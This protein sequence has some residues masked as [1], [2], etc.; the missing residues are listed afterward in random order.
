MNIEQ[1]DDRIAEILA[2]DH[3]LDEVNIKLRLLQ[4]TI[5]KEKSKLLQQ[6]KIVDSEYQDVVDVN[7]KNKQLK[8]LGGLDDRVISME[9]DEYRLAF[10]NLKKLKNELVALEYQE[11]VL[12]NKKQSLE[13]LLIELDKLIAKKEFLIKSSAS[14]IKK[15]ELE[16]LSNLL[17]LKEIEVDDIS[18]YSACFEQGFSI[19]NTIK[20]KLSTLNPQTEYLYTAKKKKQ[21][22]EKIKDIKSLSDQLSSLF[23]TLINANHKDIKKLSFSSQIF[24]YLK[25]FLNNLDNGMVRKNEFDAFLLKLDEE[26]KKLDNTKARLENLSRTT[27]NEKD[28]LRVDYSDW[29]IK[30]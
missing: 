4:A 27:L 23:D 11:S 30:Y 25:S 17:K 19:F 1:I 18:G 3:L 12:L 10:L 6:E 16:T 26:L 22:S 9:Q 24:L 5:E 20:E 2:S 21:Q 29:I 13:A 15:R 14:A 7:K 28:Q 8:F